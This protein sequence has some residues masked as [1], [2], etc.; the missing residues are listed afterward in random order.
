[1]LKDESHDEV[2]DQRASK[3]EEGKID[4]EKADPVGPYTKLPP[5][6]IANA[7]GISFEDVQDPLDHFARFFRMRSPIPQ[8]KQR[9]GSQ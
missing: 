7:K 9:R 8:D 2:K 6:P 1:M 3:R 4:E 5:P